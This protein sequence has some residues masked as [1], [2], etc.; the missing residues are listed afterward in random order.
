MLLSRKAPDMVFQI[1]PYLFE[2]FYILDKIS[3]DIETAWR[4]VRLVCLDNKIV[5]EKTKRPHYISV[6]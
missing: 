2:L 3:E 1:I 4:L 5:V 6:E